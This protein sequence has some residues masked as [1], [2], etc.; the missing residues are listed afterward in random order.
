MYKAQRQR[1]TKQAGARSISLRKL[2]SQSDQAPPRVEVINQTEFPHSCEVV[3]KVIAKV[4]TTSS[5]LDTAPA[6]S[7]SAGIVAVDGWG[8]RDIYGA[9]T[10]PSKQAQDGIPRSSDDALALL[11]PSFD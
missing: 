10:S 8:G 7:P 11:V 3:V 1:A 2:Q 6:L 9:Q 5:V 4:E